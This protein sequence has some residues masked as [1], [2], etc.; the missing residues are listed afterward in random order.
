MN[1]APGLNKVVLGLW[2]KGVAEDGGNKEEMVDVEEEDARDVSMV[3]TKTATSTETK[4]KIETKMGAGATNDWSDPA[5]LQKMIW[6]NDCNAGDKSQTQRRQNV[7]VR[8]MQS[9][10]RDWH[11]LYANEIRKRKSICNAIWSGSGMGVEQEN[12]LCTGANYD[13]N[14]TDGTMTGETMMRIMNV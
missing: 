2:P 6:A 7:L 11:Q 14:G 9:Q 5:Q 4:T 8:A 10:R 3:E 12:D 13:V 1:G